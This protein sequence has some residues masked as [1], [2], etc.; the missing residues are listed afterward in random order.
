[1]LR[2]HPGITPPE[3]QPRARR[4]PQVKS[5]VYREHLSASIVVQDTSPH[6]EPQRASRVFPDPSQVHRRAQPAHYAAQEHFN[7]AARQLSAYRVIREA[8]AAAARPAARPVR[9]DITR[10]AMHRHVFPVPQAHFSRIPAP[11]R[12]SPAQQ[13]STPPL[14]VEAPA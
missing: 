3:T 12:A 8:I 11:A 13:V 4:A 1:M 10:Q 2:V 5:L 14:V 9:P 6:Q 7:Q